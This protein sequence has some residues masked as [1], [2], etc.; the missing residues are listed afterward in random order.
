[1][2]TYYF[3]LFCLVGFHVSAQERPWPPKGWADSSIF[4]GGKNLPPGQNLK[5]VLT[6]KNGDSLVGYIRLD[7]PHYPF[8]HNGCWLLP[9]D[10]YT[11]I[12]INVQKIRNLRLQAA[13]L[14][15]SITEIYTLP[16][17]H[18]KH[19]F[20]RLIA[21]KGTVAIY[22]RSEG[23]FSHESSWA[24]WK[25]HRIWDVA[26][27]EFNDDM[28]LMSK[29]DPIKIYGNYRIYQFRDRPAEL[30][31]KFINDR[32]H[33]SFKLADFKTRMDMINYVLDAENARL[34]AS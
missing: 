11:P 27:D 3:I 22:D 31:L 4:Y 18:P 20:W 32:Y 17:D 21:K 16:I 23:I 7:I 1:M 10:T 24:T 30:I 29:G 34:A 15:R 6:L 33:K 2:R 19:A 5:G 25:N 14:G 26:A 13:S 9:K 28:L 12:W 8:R